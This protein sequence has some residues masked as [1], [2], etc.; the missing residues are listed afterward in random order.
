M[1]QGD[2]I[3]IISYGIRILPLIKNIKWEI[4]DVKYPSYADNA[5]ALGRFAR[6]ETYFDS[7]TLQGLGRGYHPKPTKS[8]LIVRPDNIE[9]GKMF[10]VRHR[11]RVC[12]GARYLRG[13]IGDENSK[14]N[15]LR[16]ST[17]TWE[18]NINTIR[19]TAGK[20][21]QESYS[22]VVCAIQSEWIFIQCLTWYTGNLFAGVEKMIRETFLPRLFF[23]KTKT[24]SHV[25]G[26]LSTTPVRKAVMG[27][28]NPV[29]SAQEKYLSSTR[30]S[31]ELVR[32]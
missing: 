20:Y 32:A 27:L 19:K 8:E 18:K 5:G 14:H 22:A 15:R 21:P 7:L 30:G 16:D 29:T 25:V 13:Y 17:M 26:D 11:F 1:A 12:T 23:G 6:L 2:P 28:L 9:A 10:G 31:A 3:T 4:P 24:L